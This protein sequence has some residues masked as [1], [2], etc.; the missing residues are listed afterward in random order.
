M[1]S[2]RT[3][4]FVVF[5]LNGCALGSWAPRV[6][7]MSTQVGAVPGSLGLALLGASVGL[8]V[9][10]TITGRLVERLGARLVMALSTVAAALMLAALGLATSVLWLGLTLFALGA[11]IGVLDVAMNVGAVFVEREAGKPLMA[12]FH[13]GFS[14]GALAG[15]LF[16]GLAASNGWSPS[17]QFTLAALA[18]ILVL[19]TVVR[20]LPG[21]KPTHRPTEK[22]SAVA[23]I[24]RPVLWLLA[25]I[26]LCSAIAEGASA[27]WSALLLVSE[28]GIGEGP[29]ALAYAAFSLAMAIARLTGGALQ[30]KVGERPVLAGG[31]LLAATGLLAAALISSPV[32]GF[33]G[34][35][36]AGAGLAASF[37]VALGLAGEAGKRADG[38]GGER[39]I[40]FVTSVAYTGFLAGPPAIGG[41]AQLTSLST[42]FIVV[43][44][45]AALIAPAT[46]AA[47]RAGRRERER[48]YC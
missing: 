13:A 29:A 3:A 4:V 17:R 21:I 15:A 14:F 20:A 22:R 42:S 10:A 39:E 35:A 46:V 28:H 7:A 1:V 2:A 24:K 23:P 26:A 9:A 41:I 8:L 18:A 30:A 32:I 43:A 5:A 16:A 31:A 11:A 48:S 37:P 12:S 44:L 45:V 6:P 25:T 38:G 40:A 33:V 27:D 47:L 19:L 36:L 34:F